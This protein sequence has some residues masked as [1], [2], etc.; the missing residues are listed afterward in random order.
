MFYA[1]V[2]QDKVRAWVL[3]QGIQ[4]LSVTVGSSLSLEPPRNVTLFYSL[5]GLR[6][7]PRTGHDPSRECHGSV[8]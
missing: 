1:Y 6:M 2:I 5:P 7:G 3:K 8:F 4:Q